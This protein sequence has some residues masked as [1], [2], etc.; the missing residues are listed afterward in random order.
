MSIQDTKKVNNRDLRFLKL[1]WFLKALEKKGMRFDFRSYTSRFE[2][3]HIVYIA[4]FF[5]IDLGYKFKHYIK[6][7]YS[8]ELAEDYLLLRRITVPNEKLDFD[9]THLREKFPDIE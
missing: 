2:L 5:G 3:Q 8:K 7:P 9:I 4:K 1:L 6:G